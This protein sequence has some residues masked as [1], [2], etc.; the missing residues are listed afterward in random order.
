MAELSDDDELENLKALLQSVNLLGQKVSEDS[1]EGKNDSGA[2]ALESV[3]TT[4]GKRASIAVASLGGVSVV[5]A[6]VT[7][8]LDKVPNK[9][10]LLYGMGAS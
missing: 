9:V 8:A 2:T 7:N 10:P 6:W 4:V 5:S 3:I 1:N